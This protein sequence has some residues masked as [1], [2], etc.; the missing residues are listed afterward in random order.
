MHAQHRTTNLTVIPVKTGKHLL[1]SMIWLACSVFPGILHA[2]SHIDE[3]PGQGIAVL[4]TDN[5]LPLVN[6]A[7]PDSQ[8][9]S[10]NHYQQ[11]DVDSQGA[12]LNNSRA[13]SMTHIGG[14]IDGNPNM[15][16][17]EAELIVNQTHSTA[18]SQLQGMIEIGGQK[19]DVIMANPAGLV[20]G[21]GFINAGQVG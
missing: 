3:Q 21:G 20:V 15:A 14:Q 13:G 16:G 7:A 2:Q 10:M 11:F 19:A 12:I 18:P 6:I 17:G 9:I 1:A 5:G 4:R 8:G